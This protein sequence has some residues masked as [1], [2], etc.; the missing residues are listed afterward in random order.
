[1]RL[2]GM[3]K[4]EASKRPTKT[5][6]PKVGRKPPEP[7][8]AEG[9]VKLTHWQVMKS[10]NDMDVTSRMIAQA[11]MRQ[12]RALGY[13]GHFGQWYRDIM[14]GELIEGRVDFT[15]RKLQIKLR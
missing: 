3:P 15:P 7:T 6:T 10:L 13:N 2:R 5:R 9:L 14:R 11:T 12:A 1:M 8:D 4:T